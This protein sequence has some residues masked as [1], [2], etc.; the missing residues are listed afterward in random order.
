MGSQRL[1]FGHEVDLNHLVYLSKYLVSFCAKT[2]DGRI[3][4]WIERHIT[5]LVKVI[6]FSPILQ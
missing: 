1:I 6:E 2:A 5:T 4:E 3:D